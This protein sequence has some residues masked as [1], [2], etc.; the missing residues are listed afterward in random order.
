MNINK[1]FYQLLKKILN[2]LILSSTTKKSEFKFKS[3]SKSKN[4]NMSLY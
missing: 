4:M 1:K 2:Y 3:K